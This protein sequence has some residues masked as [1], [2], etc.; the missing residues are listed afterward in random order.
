MD[1]GEKSTLNEISKL[2]QGIYEID[3][4]IDDDGISDE[5]IPI[6]LKLTI[7]KDEFICDFRGSSKQVQ[8]PINSS[9]TGLV[10]AVRTIF[11]AITNPSQE[12]N[13]GAF[14]PLKIITDKGSIIS[15]QRPAPVSMY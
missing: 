9:Y 15:A 4:L 5:Q 8:G 1:Q 6:K 10:S 12:V 11:L 7:T 3:E 2:P 13:D 14:R